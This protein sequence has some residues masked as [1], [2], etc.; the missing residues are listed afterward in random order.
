MFEPQVFGSKCT[1]LKKVLATLLR[2]FGTPAVIRRPWQWLGAPIVIRRPGNCAPLALFVTPFYA[3][4]VWTSRTR[5]QARSQGGFAP[6]KFFAPPGK[7]C[8]T[9]LE[10]IGHSSKNLGPS[11]K[12]LRPSWCPKLVTGLLGAHAR[13]PKITL[14][15]MCY[16]HQCFWY[17]CAAGAFHVH[18]Q[19]LS[20]F[21]ILI[22]WSSVI[23]VVCRSIKDWEPLDPET[24]TVSPRVSWNGVL[25]TM[26]N[27]H[28]MKHPL[29][30]HFISLFDFYDCLLKDWTLSLAVFC[31]FS[32]F[33]ELKVV[34]EMLHL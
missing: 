27:S 16:V 24:L 4:R 18:H 25:L 32:N 9:S 6:Q 29:C 21:T 1:V 11:Q 30:F 2:L 3:L 17:M 15:N 10:T 14:T 5:W 31:I 28:L 12:P 7:M 8:W 20:M 34:P 26:K 19:Y 13:T 33:S 23:F 22:T